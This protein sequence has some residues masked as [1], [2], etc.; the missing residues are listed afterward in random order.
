[1]LSINIPSQVR[2]AGSAT[3]K[4]FRRRVSFDPNAK[5][6]DGLSRELRAFEAVIL[7]FFGA[8]ARER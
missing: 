8:G 5:S 7:S 1:M 4:F 6:F 2:P 3:Q